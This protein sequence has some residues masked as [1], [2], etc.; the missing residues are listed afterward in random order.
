MKHE[1]KHNT[2]ISR[3]QTPSTKLLR[4]TL[5]RCQR[6]SVIDTSKD[7]LMLRWQYLTFQIHLLQACLVVFLYL[8]LYSDFFRSCE[9]NN[10]CP[11]SQ[12]R[13]I[14]QK[15][16]DLD[17]EADDF[18]NKISSSLCTD[19]SVVKFSWRSIQWFLRTFANRQTNRQRD[20][21]T[22][23]GYYITSLAVVIKIFILSRGSSDCVQL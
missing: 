7:M 14:L 11:I 18:Q 10:K 6:L 20:K 9:P 15:I 5:R 13:R 21:Q 3:N 17:P 2:K 4:V 23:S 16:L 12:C 22:N 1:F 19:T 8:Q